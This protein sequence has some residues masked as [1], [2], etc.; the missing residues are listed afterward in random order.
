MIKKV[1]IFLLLVLVV[2]QFIHHKP[3]KASGDQPN[4]IGKMYVVPEEVKTILV[5]A[6]NDCHT[7]NTRYP[8]YSNIQPVDWWLTNH[9]Q[10][11]KKGLNLDE[12][13]NRSLRF[14]YNKLGDVVKLVKEGDMP[15]D[16]YTWLHKDA[17][18]TADEKSTLMNW[19]QAIID[20]ME[21]KYP[22]DSL[23]RKK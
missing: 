19:A 2:I 8:W 3:N 5:E 14:R 10:G 1:L 23:K 7:N 15:L 22:I 12:F 9:I 4:F 6:C 21:A 18:L 17:R 16:S 20:T 11:G 13:T